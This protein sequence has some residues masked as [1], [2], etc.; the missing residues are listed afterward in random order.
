MADIDSAR[1]MIHVRHGKGG[2]DRYVPLPERTV[3]LLREY[4]VT[5]RNP[6]WMFPSEGRDHVE[7][8]S[9]TEPM[10]KYSVQS[11]IP[12]GDL[13]DGRAGP[14]RGRGFENWKI[15]KASKIIFG[16]F[17]AYII[18]LCLP[19]MA[20]SQTEKLGI[21]QY[22][23]PKGWN[24]TPKDNVVA[25]SNLNQTTG[26]FG[27][28]TVYGATPS[29]GNPQN[30][31][32]KEWNNLVVKPLQAEANPKTETQL[33]DGWTVI[34][35]GASVE[36]QG[37]KSLAFLTVFSGFGKTVSVLGVFNDEAYMTQLAAFVGSIEMDKAAADNPAPQREESLPQ[38]PAANAAAMHAAALVK[39]FENNEVRANQVWVGKRVRIYGTVNTIE[40]GKDGRIVLTFKSSITT[41]NNARCFFN[42][43]QSSRVAALSA[44]KEATVEGTVRG[45]GGGF[46]NS[47][48]FLILED[49]IVP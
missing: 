17:V 20:F 34:A 18:C 26:G 8:K 23:P 1:R 19:Q 25:W 41:Y 5:H 21:V 40:I 47:K 14:N 32:T 37:S 16:L 29:V 35:G 4:W 3:E 11:I 10:V 6:V 24:R 31:F 7:L 28:I 46:D 44:H 33:A 38:A 43:S 13:T 30:D 9:S 45:L 22:T 15:M 2:K 12:N 49:C 39:E 36:F 42:K 48:A 27:I